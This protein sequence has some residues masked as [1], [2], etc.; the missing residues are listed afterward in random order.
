MI[1]CLIN[2]SMAALTMALPTTPAVHSQRDLRRTD[3]GR[4]RQRTLF[5]GCGQGVPA[6]AGLCRSCYRSQSHSRSHFDGN[7]ESVLDRDRGC[8]GCGAGNT[9]RLHVHHRRP[10]LH[11]PAWLITLCA[12][13]HVRVHRLGAIR[14]WLPEHLIEL[15]MEQ[16]A[17]V[18]VQ[19]Q[20][21]VAV[22][23]M[24]VAA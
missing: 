16:H 11:D 14:H 22:T 19:L 1:K 7:R 13:C 6:I 23:E 2:S 3:S 5:C 18:P 4:S 21:P 8:R 15:W 12:A 10:G 20:F 17:G 24:A 9:A